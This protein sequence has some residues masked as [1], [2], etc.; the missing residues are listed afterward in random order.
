MTFAIVL[1]NLKMKRIKEYKIK[2]AKSIQL[3][4]EGLKSL[5]LS[6]LTKIQT[7]NCNL[8]SLFF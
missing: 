7:L 6:Y 3:S 5:Y 4:F 2:K 1:S 8:A